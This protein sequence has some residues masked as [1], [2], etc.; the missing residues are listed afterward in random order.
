M[1]TNKNF[2]QSDSNEESIDTTNN[3]LTKSENKKL[4]STLINEDEIIKSI[5]DYGLENDKQTIN[6][7]KFTS[8]ATQFSGFSFKDKFETIPVL[9]STIDSLVEKMKNEIKEYGDIATQFKELMYLYAKLILN[10]KHCLKIII[11]NLEK[12]ICDIKNMNEN[13]IFLK[14]SNSSNISN[15]EF[16]IIEELLSHTDVIKDEIDKIENDLKLL[17]NSVQ[18][19]I[20]LINKRIFYANCSPGLAGLA[21]AFGGF[22]GSHSFLNFSFLI[23]VGL[24]S[25]SV[26]SF[27]PFGKYFY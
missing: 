25:A 11:P 8:I 7:C 23:G 4:S 19:K 26:F 6:I 1:Q 12:I 13:E 18:E 21:G 27:P 10:T 20:N 22:S 3:S 24:S 5:T 16:S 14:Q 17:E 9:M 15:K 2:S